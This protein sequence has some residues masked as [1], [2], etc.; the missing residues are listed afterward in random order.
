M[1]IKRSTMLNRCS[2]TSDS[3][4]PLQ[5]LSSIIDKNR[6]L[7]GCD[8][9]QNKTG[10]LIDTNLHSNL[11]NLS[12]YWDASQKYISDWHSTTPKWRPAFHMQRYN[13]R[14]VFKQTQLVLI[15]IRSHCTGSSMSVGPA[16][17][18]GGRK[19]SRME[20]SRCPKENTWQ[21]CSSG[22]LP[23]LVQEEMQ[24]MK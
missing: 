5:T 19:L 11:T 21:P 6:R 2:L 4:L 23:A 1:I 9:C 20:V 8:P 16:F 24:V 3:S 7:H 18:T 15:F 14:F 13:C 12:N 22:A 10:M 17:V